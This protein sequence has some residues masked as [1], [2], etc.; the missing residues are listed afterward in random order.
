MK[1]LYKTLLFILLIFIIP[2]FS[3]AEELNFNP[4][5]Q[6]NLNPS[7]AVKSVGIGGFDAGDI[8]EGFK[9]I[10]PFNLNNLN[11][12]TNTPISPRMQEPHQGLPAVSGESNLPE[13]NLKQFLTPKDISTDDL[14]E[15]VKSV[16]S[17]VI[18]IFLVVISIVSQILRLILGFLS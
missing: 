9:F 7:D 18:E 3:I 6:L 16:I 10:S 12:D 17:L 8:L 14:G 5:L 11:I 4:D 2:H 1:N 13:I 15:A